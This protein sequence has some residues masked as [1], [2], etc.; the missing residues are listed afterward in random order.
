M[1]PQVPVKN[2][3]TV[4]IIFG[5]TGDLMGKKIAPALFHLYVK[6]KLPKLFRIIGFSRRDITEDE[7]KES[8]WIILKNHKDGKAKAEDI[9]NFLQLV[10]YHKGNFDTKD[11]YESLA[12]SLGI[13]DGRWNACSNKLF[14]LAVPP[15]NYKTI[16]QH[17]S[18]SGLTIPCGGD[19]GWTRVIVEKPFGN[20]LKT[21]Q[22]LD[23]L[24]GKL[25]KEEQIY[26]IDHYL[27]KEMLQN[28]LS[29]RFSNSLFERDWNNGSIE[30]IEV[31][32]LE[33][34]G[35]ENRG[36]FYDKVGA[37]R[38]VGQNHLL[39]MLALTTMDQP[40][41][42]DA[43]SVRTKRGEILS[44]LKQFTQEDVKQHTFRGQYKGYT[45]T[46]GV[47]KD[48]DTETYFKII[49][50]LSDPRWLG[51]PIVLEGGKKIMN[52]KEIIVTFKHEAP[53][54]CPPNAKEHYKNR[55]IFRLEP[56][57]EIE[58]EFWVKKPGLEYEMEKQTLNYLYRDERKKAQYIEEYEKL[59]LDCI[60]GNQLLFVSTQ[61]V[62]AMWQFTDPIV[63]A[64]EENA[65][66]LHIYE[67]NK[68]KILNE[69]IKVQPNIKYEPNSRTVGI[70][71]L[72]KM[73][74]N[75]AKRLREKGWNIV[76]F[77][78]TFDVA[79]NL[80]KDGGIATK[81]VE[82]LI[83]RLPKPRVVL[84]SLPMGEPT[85][86]MVENLAA[87]LEPGDT[88]I[89]GANAF[90]K[91]T[92]KNAEKAEKMAINYLDAGISGGPGG[93]RNGACI[94]VGGKQEAFEKV[95]LL[96]QD[97]AKK[98][99][100][101]FFKGHG[102]G[103]FVKM[104]HN[105]IEYGMMQALAEGVTVL[106]K[107]DYDLDLTRVAEIYN[108]G[109]V[110]ESRLVGW[111]EDAFETFGQDLQGVS[112]SVAHTGEGESTVKTAEEL[113]VEVPVIKNSLQ[114]RID[115]EKNPSYTGQVLSALRNMFGGHSIRRDS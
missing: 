62:Q 49:A 95:E 71:G 2:I 19:E 51:V 106:K 52:N 48:S 17:L 20:D 86:G 81:T 22:D 74:G 6:N 61:E 37:F 24:L 101:Q 67:P 78:R 85:N 110:I 1:D 47:E 68:R 79:E 59:L 53:C 15:Q 73:G 69:A 93:A 39:Q 112:G 8:V 87:F 46:L 41:S 91:E 45:Q 90:F 13:I 104:V 57:E 65:V 77:N 30:K 5:A 31:R 66:S 3:P 11:A 44:L 80:V 108:N 114:F 58:I 32:L 105:G 4:F 115:S 98:N 54:M 94:M 25:F 76:V 43:E 60:A 83:Q 84:L 96:F 27:A 14:Y 99:A 9:E 89:D 92:R 63:C 111:L 28:I 107:S 35:I 26:R 113:G 72:G 18:D 12:K 75:I 109:S 82:E 88:I 34:I 10:D 21:A 23:E 29:F 56:K 50:E 103:H 7:F 33:K 70:I 97:M 36:A 100:V 40:Q 42:L 16:F 64:W 38:D 102:A 55:I